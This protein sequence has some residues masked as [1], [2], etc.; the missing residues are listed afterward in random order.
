MIY[1]PVSP[2]SV[3]DKNLEVITETSQVKSRQNP[4]LPK[5]SCTEL[6]W[7]HLYSADSNTHW[8]CI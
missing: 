5:L 8:Q 4:T 6:Q 7:E 1:I 3:C 2:K